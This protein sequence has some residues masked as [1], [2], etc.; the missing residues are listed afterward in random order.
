MRVRPEWSAESPQTQLETPSAPALGGTRLHA[1][2]R[3]ANWT[4]AL[5]APLGFLLPVLPLSMAQKGMV[6]SA[7][8]WATGLGSVDGN[9]VPLHQEAE[10]KGTVTCKGHRAP[11]TATPSYGLPS[12]AGY[13]YFPL[14]EPESG[15]HLCVWPFTGAG[16]STRGE[17]HRSSCRLHN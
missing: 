13:P 3:S 17:N 14:H 16:R 10:P 7:A 2:P 5:L 1:R 9:R 15:W 6:R 8:G 11:S 12:W 4:T